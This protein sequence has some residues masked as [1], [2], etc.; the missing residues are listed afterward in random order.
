MLK[1]FHLCTSIS[2]SS[3]PLGSELQPFFGP[4][5]WNLANF[6]LPSL[7]S[8]PVDMQIVLQHIVQELGGTLSFPFSSSS[9]SKRLSKHSSKDKFPQ[10]HDAKP[11]STTHQNQS[12]VLFPE[13]PYSPIPLG[14]IRVSFFSV[15]KPMISLYLQ[16]VS[17]SCFYRSKPMKSQLINLNE[18][19]YTEWW[20]QLTSF[21]LFQ[22]HSTNEM[23]KDYHLERTLVE[24]HRTA[25]SNCC[26]TAM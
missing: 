16:Q 26:Y 14:F 20:T 10:G 5:F 13:Q 17:T 18:S 22:T 4:K 7:I 24:L 12:L 19:W 11:R 15:G 23:K 2:N 8:N 3:F 1:Q 21:L 6:F 25:Y 9:W